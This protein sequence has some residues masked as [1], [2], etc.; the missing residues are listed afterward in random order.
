MSEAFCDPAYDVGA[1]MD[2]TVEAIA[3]LLEHARA[4]GVPVVYAT[5]AFDAADPEASAGMWGR[6]V[7]ALLQLVDSDPRATGVHPR[8]A[9]AESDASFIK[10]RSSAFFGTPLEELL[11]T[12][13]V[14]T[15][16]VT[17]C[18]TSGCIRATALDGVS[19]GYRIVVPEECVAD[20]A[21]APHRA[22]LADID[23]KYGD[24]LALSEVLERL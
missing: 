19:L 8:L 6:K 12:M 16:I 17:G 15:L 22:N 2:A 13:D 9:P 10:T 5:M 7:P 14:D 4:R 20:R 3:T 1:P 21:E 11:E 23:A 24:V 18:S